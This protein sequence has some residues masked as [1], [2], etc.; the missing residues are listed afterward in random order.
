LA[1]VVQY[2]TDALDGDGGAEAEDK[3]YQRRR[4]YHS[5]TLD[6]M[7]AV[8]GF[9]DPESADVHEMAMGIARERDARAA[10]GRTIAQRTRTRSR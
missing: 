6:K 9:F 4:Y 8:D 2:V 10:E 3:R 1:A 7:L 5:R